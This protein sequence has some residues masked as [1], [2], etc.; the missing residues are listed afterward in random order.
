MDRK[1]IRGRVAKLG[2]PGGWPGLRALGI[3]PPVLGLALLAA[4]TVR[5]GLAFAGAQPHPGEPP[6]AEAA[7][8]APSAPAVVSVDQIAPQAAEVAHLL[9]TFAA[10]FVPGPEIDAIRRSLPAFSADLAQDLERTLGLLAEQPSLD[11]LQILDQLWHERQARSAAWLNR[12]TERAKALQAAQ[13]R[14]DDLHA[15]WKRT[16]DSEQAAAAPAPVLQHIGETI[17]A[18]EA[19]QPPNRA[20]RDEILDLQAQVASEVVRCE[21]ALARI[22]QTERAIVGRIFA[23]D[24]RP[25][26]SPEGWSLTLVALPTRVAQISAEYWTRVLE[27]GRDPSEHLPVHLGLFL[28]ALVAL[29]AARGQVEEWTSTGQDLSRVTAV[30]DHPVAAALVLA[31]FVA[32]AYASPAP[33]V[34]KQLLSALALAPMIVLARPLV[35]R[36]MVSVLYTLGLLFALDTLR[37]AF[38]GTPPLVDQT[39]V[40]VESL[41]GIL[42]LGWL[43][44]RAWVAGAPPVGVAPSRRRLRRLLGWLILATLAI[45]LVASTLGYLRVSRLSTP[46][47]LVGGADALWLYAAV[48]VSTAVIAFALRLWPLRRLRMVQHHRALLET[49]IHRTLM[50]IA[51]GGWFFRYLSYLGLWEPSLNLVTSL[52]DSR[53]GLGSFSTSVGDVLAFVATILVAYLLSSLL[54]F[55]LEEDIYPRAGVPAGISYAASS[56]LHYVI[57]AG[58]FLMALGVLGVTLTQV[59]VLAGAFGVGIG[60]G[61]QSV[62]NNFVSGLILLFERPVHVGDAVQL[63]ELQG[64]VRRI[65]IRASVVRTQDGA[66]IIVP[67]AD[68]VTKQVTNWTLSDQQR[69]VHLPVGVNYG[70]PPRQVIEILE[71]VARAHP[72]AAPDPPPKCLFIGYGDS[73]VD[74]ELRVWTDYAK[75]VQVRSDLTVAVYDA[76]RAAGLSFPFPQREVRLLADAPAGAQPT[77]S[78]P[79]TKG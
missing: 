51:V 57:V 46:A 58:A 11:A 17:A 64:W 25:I 20:Q 22:G 12:L 10:N 73:S 33:F 48:E 19:A 74:F 78:D 27:Y 41:T 62:V 2:R 36:V 3:R 9:R 56:L 18:I 68:L 40:F 66:E 67:N 7:A 61:L 35:D 16:R 47:V 45:G 29:L 24:G 44:L 21:T 59:T 52:L 63:S 38:G 71:G 49:R 79:G 1:S 34:V 39:L 77:G 6:G 14:L 43:F 5:G 53:V 31:L 76:V 42:V 23:Q 4:L 50:W 30:F 55:V 26:W 8:P 13:D 37:H 69:R 75:A 72:D 54:R 65:G 32:T 15:L 60:F 28:L 70:A